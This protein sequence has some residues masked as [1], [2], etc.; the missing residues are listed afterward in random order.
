MVI[1]IPHDWR[2]VPVSGKVPLW[3][4][5]PNKGVP[6]F[7]PDAGCGIGLV[8]GPKSGGTAAID[9]DGTEACEFFKERFP[10]IVLPE[11]PT[12]YSGQQEHCQMAFRVPEALWSDIGTIKVSANK[13]LEFRWDR[14]QSV[15][16]PSLHPSG[17]QY[18]WVIEPTAINTMVEM[19]D[20]ILRYWLE[21]CR[22]PEPETSGPDISEWSDMPESDRGSMVRDLLTIIRH[23]GVP[24]YDDWRDITWAVA[25]EVGTDAAMMIMKQALPETRCGEYR[26]LLK[27]FKDTK[28]PTMGTLVFLADKLNSTEVKMI[29]E[30]YR[31]G[32]RV[33]SQSELEQL[34]ASRL[35]KRRRQ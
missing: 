31:P 5:W 2:F 35:F 23:G 29:K 10:G 15:I 19:P 4:D 12:W 14:S 21:E 18:E 28:A 9:F 3:V 16:P 30:K 34:R 17:R 27:G 26:D 33:A 1:S 11:V 20:Q 7:E 8:L 24:G 13:K 25:H 22:R 6:Y 32:S